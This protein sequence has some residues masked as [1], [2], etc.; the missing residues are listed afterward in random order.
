[1]DVDYLM[2]N[3]WIVGDAMECED[4]IRALHSATGGFGTLLNITVDSD[5]TAWDH[6]SL[7][8][9]AEKVGP[10]IADLN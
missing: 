2:E 9:L 8:L 7:R 10:R 5:D 3:V 6:E 1:V 4:K